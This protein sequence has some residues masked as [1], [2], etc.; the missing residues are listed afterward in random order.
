M[1]RR[2][3]LRLFSGS[4]AAAASGMSVKEAARALGDEGSMAMNVPA[5]AEIGQMPVTAVGWGSPGKS[6]LSALCRERERL[7]YANPHMPPHI[8]TKKSWSPAF[9][10]AV[11]D[12]E[13]AILE[14]MIDRL[15]RDD[16]FR[17]HVAAALGLED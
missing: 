3:I 16:D 13:L 17:A 12:R 8:A 2:S 9:K 15:E 1:D 4:A 11:F 5:S 7:T 6:L 10:K 14:A